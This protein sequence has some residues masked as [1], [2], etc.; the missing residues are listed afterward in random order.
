MARAIQRNKPG[1]RNGLIWS[2][3]NW[4]TMKYPRSAVMMAKR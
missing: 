4:R 2:L 1:M 3:R